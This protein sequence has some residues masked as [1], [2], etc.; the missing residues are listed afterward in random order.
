MAMHILD[1][2]RHK[3][4]GR[5]L[6]EEEI[7]F[8]V[9]GYTDGAIPDYQA[10]ALL[11]AIW[12]R[13]MTDEETAVLTQAMAESG[14]RLDLSRFG[15]QSVDKHSTGGVGDKTT[16][17]AAPLAAALGGRVTKLSGRGLGHTGGTVDKLEA[18]PGY[19]TDLPPEEFLRQV[20]RI[21]IAVIGQ[22]GNLAPADKKLYAL[23][24]VTGT[25]DSIPLITASIM[26]KKLAAGAHAIVLDVKVGS[27]AFMKTPEQARALA[28]AMVT[29][30]RRC[31]RQ[32]AALLTDM[33]RPLG[34]A[35]GNALEVQ[36]AAA[37]LRGDPQA[38]ADLRQ[39]SVALAAQMVALLRK[40]EPS[41]AERLV[42]GALQSGA[43]Y[44]KMREW[45]AAQ[46]GDVRVLEEP[47]RFPAPACHVPVTAAR[48]GYITAMDAAAIGRAGVLL[49][50]GRQKK[51]EAIDPAAG[52][53]LCRKTGEAVKAGEPLAVL[54]TNRPET[55]AEA[56]ER[57]RA[58]VT[59]GS[60][61]PADRPLIYEVI[62]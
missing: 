20:E 4:E 12:F 16:L 13:G 21:G 37:V 17:I 61:P 19:R 59:I 2:I 5:A 42:T 60:E 50:A 48:D 31:G 22:T 49:G 34:R 41:E 8:F 7:R 55:I 6:T 39:V 47:S 26:S 35:V 23:R 18:I 1:L 15:E 28:Q 14:D 43:G 10:S 33:N 11:M 30:G 62:R 40:I 54:F 32:M 56:A 38:P 29:I 52:L 36:E 9:S 46:G 24:D 51:D 58:A 53:C 44:A 27:G 25:V 3:Q 57:L 45:I